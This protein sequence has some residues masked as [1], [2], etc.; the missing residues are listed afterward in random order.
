MKVIPG[1]T[2]PLDIELKIKPLQTIQGLVVDAENSKPVAGAKVKYF[3]ERQRFILETDT[4]E[5]GKFQFDK[6]PTGTDQSVIY[7][8][9]NEKVSSAEMVFRIKN[10]DPSGQINLKLDDGAELSGYIKSESTGKPIEN[11]TVTITPPYV[12]GFLMQTATD[13]N[14][15]YKFTNLPPGEYV[16]TAQNL[17]YFTYNERRLSFLSDRIAIMSGQK[18]KKDLK[19]K[20][21][22]TFEGKVVD[23]NGKP[24]S[25]AVVAI[26]E[27][28]TSNNEYSPFV[29]RTDDNGKF[30]ITTGRINTTPRPKIT[31]I[32]S[33]TDILKSY[34]A[35]RPVGED[36]IEA[37]S[38][39]G[40]Y[41][42]FQFSPYREGSVIKG[43]N[44]KL[45]GAMRI[46]GKVT[47]PN[48]NPLKDIEVYDSSGFDVITYT[49]ENG[50]Y[51]LSKFPI[52]W[53]DKK[54]GT[55]KFLA[56]RPD[57]SIVYSFRGRTIPFDEVESYAASR[58]LYHYNQKNYVIESD[59]DI[60]INAVIEPTD[61]ITLYGT[62]SDKNNSP[63]ENARI[64]L[65]RNNADP[66]EWTKRF[67]LSGSE[68]IHTTTQ[69][70]EVQVTGT[71][72]NGFWKIYLARDNASD[73][74]IFYSS[75]IK[76]NLFSIG[77][78]SNQKKA[79]LIQDIIINENETEK[80]FN[81]QLEEENKSQ[82]GNLNMLNVPLQ[83]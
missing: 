35:K 69:A 72:E 8:Q 43:I 38:S 4:D 54:Q 77:I 12:N 49:D 73:M 22:M 68:R 9:L 24:V 30:S 32:K 1:Q 34:F 66:N 5:N 76:D 78:Y 25:G 65:F 61:L 2:K 47:D 80:E 81:V 27:A 45:N 57:T 37:F 70:L 26:D 64:V 52:R 56:P 58:G 83:F 71:D 29:V 82:N 42:R 18:Y 40:G 59:K 75:D 39:S 6:L 36:A 44:I 10:N 23:H 17:D 11:C 50:E 13:V 19:L 63:L 79:I 55:I 46:H 67:E 41:G 33:L 51:D 16:V 48:G 31:G 7:A 20:K 62:V 53:P 74:K 21:R 14:G 60:E 3:G 28:H 15:F